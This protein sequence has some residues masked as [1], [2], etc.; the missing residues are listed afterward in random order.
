MVAAALEVVGELLDARLVRDRG[1]RERRGARRLG[2]VFARL[3]VHEVELLGLGVVRLELV[4]GDRPRG[5]HAAVV[6]DLSEVLLAQ[7]EQDR[8]VELGVAADEVLLVRRE[9]RAVLVVP[10]L[11]GQVSLAEEHLAAVPVLRLARQVAAALEQQDALAGRR[12][13]PGERAAARA[14]SDD[15]DVVVVVGHG[16]CSVP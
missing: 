12:E 13:A 9:R 1:E 6:A 8:A 10:L 2:R 5:R 16:G 7:P 3:A 4:V 11:A 14:R 15:D